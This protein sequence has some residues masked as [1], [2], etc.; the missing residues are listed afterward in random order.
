MSCRYEVYPSTDTRLQAPV[1]ES[2]ACAQRS[3]QLSECSKCRSH[4]PTLPLTC[5][6]LSPKTP[7]LASP[8]CRPEHLDG[9]L[10]VLSMSCR[11]EVNPSA[12]TRLQA[13]VRESHAC[14]QRSTQLSE[15]SKCRS[16]IPTRLYRLLTIFNVCRSNGYGAHQ[17]TLGFEHGG[18]RRTV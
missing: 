1:R 17:R 3:T 15:Y 7:Y 18:T 12:D 8:R 6:A 4:T 11:Y 9:Y 10:G 5:R 14:A 2:H 13:H 16:H